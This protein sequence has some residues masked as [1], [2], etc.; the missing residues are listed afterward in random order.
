MVKIVEKNVEAIKELCERMQIQ[1]L[2]LFG[3]GISE[4]NFTSESDLDFLFQFKKDEQGL[5]I[6]GYDYFDLMFGL[7]KITGKKSR[8]GCRRKNKK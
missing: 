1:S 3:S 5:S 4:K 7:E 6:S 8:P 2:Y